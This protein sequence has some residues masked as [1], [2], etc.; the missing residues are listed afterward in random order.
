MSVFRFFGLIASAAVLLLTSGCVVG[1]NFKQPAPPQVPDYTPQHPTTTTATPN[2][3]GGEAQSF[4]EGHDIPGDW[5]TLFHSKSLNDL[6][7]RALK[8][9]PDLKSAQ[10]A[11]VVA[12]EN[13]LAQRG[14]YYPY[15]SAGFSATR[16]K[17]SPDISPV[18][19]SGA[20]NYSL[21][22]PQVT[23]SFVPDVFGLNRRTVESLK[24]Q[25]EQA[26]YALVATHITLSSNIAAAAIQEASLRAQIDTTNLLIDIATRTL[27]TLR[28]QYSK[29]Y[30]TELDIAAQEAQ[31]AQVVATLPPLQKQ[32]EQQRDLL[33]VLAGGF[34]NQEMAERFALASLQLPKELPLTLPSQLV[35]QRPDVRQ[36]EE[37]L[38][39]ASALVGVARAN[40]LPAFNLTADA[41]TM[42][43][44][45]GHVF[46]AGFWD[47]AGGLTQP[48]F[49]GKTLLHRERAAKA[50]YTQAA[51]QYRSTVLTAF[52]NVADT[53]HA[54]REDADALKAAV[55]A[56]KAAAVTLDL[57]KTQFDA[58]YAGYLSVLS[59][60]QTYQ[61]ALL[62]Q[63]QAQ[64]NRYS[65][66]AAL[67][68]ALG[69]GW[70]N[71]PDL[72]RS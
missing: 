6:I 56:T 22:T 14:Y 38:H 68:Q 67:F 59:A 49:D 23:V 61:Q 1:P 60:E 55:D 24:A 7:E 63:V 72:P 58:G 33:A 54:I 30:A 10:A 25:Q 52:Q 70:W 27:A 35:E 53:L 48:V 31:L 64:S 13:T 21:Y 3:A 26:R 42:A 16:G 50:A 2:V 43:V 34:P 15:V 20:L 44:T 28:S 9:N 4:V 45:L 36:A 51:E 39:A 11:L 71:R 57:T 5:W 40:R 65:D 47:V 46:T 69:G 17:S 41:G 29:G 18:T 8:A 37:N 62:N 12:R 19:Y 66:T 32:L